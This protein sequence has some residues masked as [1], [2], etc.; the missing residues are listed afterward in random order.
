MFG[1]ITGIFETEKMIPLNGGFP[2]QGSATIKTLMIL[3]GHYLF[4]NFRRRLLPTQRALGLTLQPT[5]PD[6]GFYFQPTTLKFVFDNEG[7]GPTVW[8]IIFHNGNVAI[9]H[10]DGKSFGFYAICDF[11][12]V[13]T[14]LSIAFR[15]SVTLSIIT[16]RRWKSQ[17]IENKTG[18]FNSGG[19]P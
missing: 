8:T 7:I 16:P 14:H 6:L 2:A 17:G 15:P 18:I 12:F 5:S 4:F 13:I 9:N 11:S 1:I 19:W 10:L 3:E